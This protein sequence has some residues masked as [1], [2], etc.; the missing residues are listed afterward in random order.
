MPIKMRIA[1]LDSSLIPV[2]KYIKLY[3]SNTAL[4]PSFLNLSN[5]LYASW[6]LKLM[7]SNFI[8]KVYTAKE[9]YA[10][11]EKVVKENHKIERAFQDH[12]ILWKKVEYEKEVE[13]LAKSLGWG[14]NE[15]KDYAKYFVC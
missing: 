7:E 15:N 14:R 8:D 5:K 2:P 12:S 1:P 3:G 4:P 9:D 13:K 10:N 6:T 11:F